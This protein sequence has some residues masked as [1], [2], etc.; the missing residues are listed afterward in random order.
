MQLNEHDFIKYASDFASPTI[1]YTAVFG[2]KIC[3]LNFE[4]I[5]DQKPFPRY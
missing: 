5:A 4:L 1:F 3:G 2:F